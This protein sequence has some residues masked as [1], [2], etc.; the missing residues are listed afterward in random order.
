MKALV[1]ILSSY[2]DAGPTRSNLRV[3]LRLLL[4][5]I[6]LVSAYSVLFH[7]L[8]EGEGQK[9]SWLTGV[10]WTLTVMTTLGFGDIT[11][12]TDAGR[13]FSIIVLV[14]GLFF[15]LVILP[16]TFIQ[17]FYA[18]WM[19]AQARARAP[20]ELPPTT[21]RHVLLTAHDPVT[22]SLIPLLER[23][24]HPYALLMAGTTEALELHDRGFKV[25]VGD[26][27]DPLTWKRMRIERAAML[28]A[29][30]GD[31]PNANIV[32]TARE[33]SGKVPIVAMAGASNS[34]DLLEL[35]GATEVI[36]LHEIMA[37]AL[38]RRVLGHD[39]NAHVI[40]EI[41]GLVIAESVVAGTPFEGKTLAQSGIRAATG[42]SIIGY[43][44]HGRLVTAGPETVLS[45][46]FVLVGAGTRAQVDAYNAAYGG[47][48][49]GCHVII[50]G[51][52]R[53]GRGTAQILREAGHHPMVVE[54]DRTR[55]ESVPGA[56]HGDIRDI[57]VLRAARAREASTIILT[58]HDDDTNIALTILFHRLRDEFQIIAR[59]SNDRNTS[60]LQRAGADLVLS[61]ASMGANLILN[62]LRANNHLLLAE[63]VTLFPAAVPPS[64]A[65]RRIAECAVRSSTGCTIIAIE[66]GGERVL[67]P[68]PEELLP[69]DGTL[70]LVGTLESEEAF[71][72]EFKPELAPIA[73][74]RRW[75]KAARRAVSGSR[76]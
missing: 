39:R 49:S 48:G 66:N 76:S 25:A 21:R 28:V 63:G 15:M 23:Y 38:A 32:F 59:C 13:L 65:G 43:W 18:P 29:N 10:Y 2:L 73:L 44:D 64:M 42:F 56:I 41:N 67:N 71:L 34:R 16:F 1:S 30:S 14:S 24:G 50:V 47:P 4:L 31:I 60:T 22:A 9:H 36:L 40:G 11:F 3:L 20:R 45:P 46:K 72:R 52:G 57:E 35:A 26:A 12:T 70:W 5:L 69:P 68:G 53:V 61:S 6:V 74:R 51:A 62:L 8:M 75:K 55:A 54:K 58:S 7:V 37:R 17:F 27:D 19:E 33:L